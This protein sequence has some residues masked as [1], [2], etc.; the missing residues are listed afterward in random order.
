MAFDVYL[1]IDGIKGESTDSGHKDWIELLSHSA[2]TQ[3]P[4]PA[5]AAS[6]ASVQMQGFHFV[7]KVDKASPKL[8]QAATTGT[9][10]PKV[11]IEVMKSKGGTKQKFMTIKMEQV[12][13]NSMSSARLGGSVRIPQTTLPSGTGL[14]AKPASPPPPHTETISLSYGSIQWAYSQ[15]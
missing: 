3:P 10:I 15:Q 11:T 5:A 9:H 13:V 6:T 4:A 2:S 12:Y 8:Y 1:Q 14:A 7:K